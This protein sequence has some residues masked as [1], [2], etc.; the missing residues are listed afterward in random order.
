[1]VGWWSV[2][3]KSAISPCFGLLVAKSCFVFRRQLRQSCYDSY[4]SYGS[5][6]L[7]KCCYILFLYVLEQQLRHSCIISWKS[8]HRPPRVAASSSSPQHWFMTQELDQGQLSFVFY[9]HTLYF[10]PQ[11][12]WNHAALPI[13]CSVVDL[14][15]ARNV[16][17]TEWC[18]LLKRTVTHT[19]IFHWWGQAFWGIG[20][21][22]TA[23][24]KYHLR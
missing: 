18:P 1:M 16:H 5:Y 6:V 20:S 10:A 3:S 9:I 4:D 14:K 19:S 12:L 22:N 17:N 23:K 8:R 11:E 2:S 21:F 15:S 7:V 13:N 24:A